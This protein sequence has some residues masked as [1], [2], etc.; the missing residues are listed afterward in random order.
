MPNGGQRHD[1]DLGVPEEPAQVLEQQRAAAAVVEGVPDR[2]DRRHEEAGADGLVQ[3]H[4]DRADEQRR[5]RQQAEHRRHEDAPHRQRHPHQ[6]HAAGTRL[7]DGRHVVQPAHGERDDEH[8][9]RPQHQQ[10]APVDAGRAGQDGLGRIQGPA[11]PGGTAGDEIACEQD[12]DGPEIDVVA[13]HVDVREHHVARA[14]H[15]RDQEVAEAAEEQG[16][17]Q[18]DHHDHAVHGDELVI[19]LGVDEVELV[20]EPELQPHHPG[21]DQRHE[22]HPDRGDAVLDRDH[23]VVLAEP[24]LRHPTVGMV[25]LHRLLVGDL[26]LNRHRYLLRPR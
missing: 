8:R 10:D 13:D 4:H 7:Q 21:Q 18:V 26:C 11:R 23:L 14:A 19:G 9:Q 22:A 1:V 16:G 3:D 5:E 15:Q 6:R 2:D 25:K 20:G 12:D 24:V 17:Q